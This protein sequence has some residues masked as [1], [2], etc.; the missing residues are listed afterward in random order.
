MQRRSTITNQATAVGMRALKR[1]LPDPERDLSNPRY[2]ITNNDMPIITSTAAN[3]STIRPNTSNQRPSS[4]VY[5]EI[6]E[7]V[8]YDEIVEDTTNSSAHT[9]FSTQHV[10]DGY[11]EPI[12]HFAGVPIIDDVT[13]SSAGKTPTIVTP[14]GDDGYQVPMLQHAGPSNINSVGTSVNVPVNPG[15]PGSQYDD[16]LN[17]KDKQEVGEYHYILHKGVK[18]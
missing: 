7:D 6:R 14:S 10:N 12:T 3:P 1:P 15:D 11:L 13:P 17:L 5:D 16:V 8:V 2:S 9:N 18:I 4:V